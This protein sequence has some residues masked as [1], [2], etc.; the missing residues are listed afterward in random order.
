MELGKDLLSMD[1][2]EDAYQWIDNR[3]KI[4]KMRS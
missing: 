2:Y 3:K 4:I 1:K